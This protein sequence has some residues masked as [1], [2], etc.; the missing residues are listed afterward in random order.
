MNFPT[1]ELGSPAFSSLLPPSRPAR[2]ENSRCHNAT[3][4]AAT[5]FSPNALAPLAAGRGALGAALQPDASVAAEEYA[6]VVSRA[7][8]HPS[9][10]RVGNHLR[11]PRPRARGDAAAVDAALRPAGD[12]AG[13]PV[14][15]AAA[16][17]RRAAAAAGA[18]AQAAAG[19]A[20]AA[21]AVAAAA[22]VARFMRCILFYFILFFFDVRFRFSFSDAESLQAPFSVQ[23]PRRPLRR[24]ALVT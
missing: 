16:G 15:H 2:E 22:G 23:R 10:W 1:T 9:C 24:E 8:E 17:A 21:L 19:P 11:V 3:R 20:V 14:Q 6:A 5:T 7:P 18:G 13:A 12:A 4:C